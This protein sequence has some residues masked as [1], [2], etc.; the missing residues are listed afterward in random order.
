MITTAQSIN[1]QGRKN[2]KDLSI[3][4]GTFKGLSKTEWFKLLGD[5]GNT[6]GDNIKKE[7]IKEDN[8]DVDLIRKKRLLAF[9]NKKI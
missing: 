3:C 9:E 6:I 2:E 4:V 7:D 8:I 1:L 5:N